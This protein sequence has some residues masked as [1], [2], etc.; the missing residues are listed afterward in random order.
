MIRLLEPQNTHKHTTHAHTIHYTHTF[1][2]VCWL[3]R[4]LCNAV[5]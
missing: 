1:A 5:H 4:V 3:L 2:S